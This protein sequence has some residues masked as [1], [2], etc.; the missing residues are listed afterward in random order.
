MC[1]FLSPHMPTRA[2]LRLWFSVGILC[3]LVLA[4]LL[5]PGLRWWL[6]PTAPRLVLVYVV[7]VWDVRPQCWENTTPPWLLRA[8]WEEEQAP[9]C[10][11][12]ALEESREE[13]THDLE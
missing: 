5:G 13:E 7:D 12:V 3:G 1:S 2:R 4:L 6:A 8:R 11:L 10:W 9:R